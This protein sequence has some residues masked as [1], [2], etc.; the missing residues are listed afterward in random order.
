MENPFAGVFLPRLIPDYMRYQ[1]SPF[2]LDECGASP[3]GLGDNKDQD[4]SLWEMH[5]NDEIRRA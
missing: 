4:M 3:I 2:G 1:G 5:L